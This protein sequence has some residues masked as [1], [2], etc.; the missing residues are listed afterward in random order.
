MITNFFIPELNNHDVQELWFQQ[1]GATCHT[2]RA[3]IDLLKDTFG[4]RLISRF[5]PVNW[6]PRSCD[7]TPLDFFSV[8]CPPILET[9]GL[10]LS[11][12]VTK[13]NTKVVFSCESGRKLI[14]NEQAMC[15]PSGQW[16]A[17]PPICQTLCTCDSPFTLKPIMSLSQ[18]RLQGFRT[19]VH[20]TSSTICPGPKGA[21]ATFPSFVRSLEIAN[22]N[23]LQCMRA[24]SFDI[25]QGPVVAPFEGGFPFWEEEKDCWGK[26]GAKF[27]YVLIQVPAKVSPIRM[28]SSTTRYPKPSS[29][30]AR[31]DTNYREGLSSS[32]WTADDGQALSP[33][34]TLSKKANTF[35]PAHLCVV[36]I[37]RKIKLG[38]LRQR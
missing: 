27:R 7:L 1:D 24:S 10:I 12:T 36:N 22:R 4:D 31:M 16:S 35:P 9:D 2:A 15:F 38:F 14:G 5:G 33:R 3:T 29:S 20:L 21:G 34:A 30:D 11:T 18:Q 32:A 25:I 26:V 17:Y 23:I 13:M 37:G 6:P 19:I 28:L 8:H